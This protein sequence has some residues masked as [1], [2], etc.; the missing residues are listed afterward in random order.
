[1]IS[2]L[3]INRSDTDWFLDPTKDMKSMI[4]GSGRVER[5]TGNIASVEFNLLYRWHSTLSRAD[6]KWMEDLMIAKTGKQV[7]DI[8]TE[9]FVRVSGGRSGLKKG[10]QNIDSRHRSAHC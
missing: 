9:D 7:D 1:M 10:A 4:A 2:I 6:T 3:G 5:G 8:T